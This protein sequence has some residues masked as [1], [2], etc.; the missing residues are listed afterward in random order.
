MRKNQPNKE[1]IKKVVGT[2]FHLPLPLEK[3]LEK[4]CHN[5]DPIN[6]NPEFYIIVRSIPNKNKQIWENLVDV[7]QLMNSLEWLKNNNHLYAEINLPANAEDLNDL[8]NINIEHQEDKT[9]I[10]NLC[11]GQ[12]MENDDDDNLNEVN[13]VK[14]GKLINITEAHDALLTLVT[15]TA[16]FYENYTIFPIRDMRTNE[17]AAN[18]YQQVYVH[19]VPL[20]RTVKH[21]DA[22]CFPILYPKGE[23]TQ[24]SNRPVRL[25]DCDFIISKLTSNDPHY[26]RSIEYLFH[27]LHDCNQ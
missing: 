15:H 9:E 1:R 20:Y 12:A 8:L 3:T 24:H 5:N 14:S 2:T 13:E 17:P 11:E 10:K 19:D 21:L 16:P 27:L 25:R 26:R 22:M 7:K 23:N 4:I 6:L 18:L